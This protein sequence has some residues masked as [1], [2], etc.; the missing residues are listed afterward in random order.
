MNAGTERPPA[1]VW[2]PSGGYPAKWGQIRPSAQCQTRKRGRPG[3]GVWPKQPHTAPTPHGRNRIIATIPTRR[4]RAGTRSTIATT[5]PLAR[6]AFPKPENVPPLPQIAITDSHRRQPSRQTAVMR[7]RTATQ[8]DC[9]AVELD[10]DW[11]YSAASMP[12]ILRNPEFSSGNG[13]MTGPTFENSRFRRTDEV[14]D[15]S[16]LMNQAPTS[17]PIRPIRRPSQ[18]YWAEAVPDGT[19][20]GSLRN[21][22]CPIRVR[23]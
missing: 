12:L 20:R 3:S 9:A 7:R 19:I 23:R 17:P 18:S 6:L 16:D 4:S 14:L 10:T 11:A 2:R 1:T 21:R 15:P 8:P 22:I 13:G 5:P